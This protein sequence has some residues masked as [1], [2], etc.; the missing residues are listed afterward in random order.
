MIVLFFFVQLDTPFVA[1]FLFRFNFGKFLS[2]KTWKYS[3]PKNNVKPY[4]PGWAWDDYNFYY[5]AEKVLSQYSNT[6][7]Y[8]INENLV[9]NLEL[10]SSA[11]N[12]QRSKT[13]NKF[14]YNQNLKRR[15]YL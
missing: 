14:F 9:P 1:S 13:E 11:N 2:K 4:G 8:I 6:V 10:D 5:A 7:K 3:R 15:Y 12:L